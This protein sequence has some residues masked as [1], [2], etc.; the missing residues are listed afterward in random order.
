MSILKSEVLETP[1][2]KQTAGAWRRAL[3]EHTGNPAATVSTR[4]VGRELTKLLT[5]KGVALPGNRWANSGGPGSDG[6]TCMAILQACYKQGIVSVDEIL[7]ALVR[8]GES[9][10]SVGGG[11]GV[12]VSQF[13]AGAKPA[14]TEISKKK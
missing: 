8:A 11:A 4:S 7:S 13:L 12:D 2:M 5:S 9:E 14:S 6:E 1:Y 3:A 10:S